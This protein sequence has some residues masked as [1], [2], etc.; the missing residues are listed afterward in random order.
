MFSYF[1][2]RPR[3]AAVESAVAKHLVQGAAQDG[4]RWKV[5]TDACLVASAF[6]NHMIVFQE[7]R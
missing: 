6:D 3:L 4:D 7:S 1:K 5:M 2:R